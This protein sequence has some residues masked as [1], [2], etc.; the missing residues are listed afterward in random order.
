MVESKF[1]DDGR[2]RLILIGGC[3][4]TQKT[5][6]SYK[7]A[8]DLGVD[9]VLSLDVVK[10]CIKAFEPVATNPYLF[11]TT[12][13]A[14]EVENLNVM[15]GYRKHAGLI[16]AYLLRLLHGFRDDKVVIVEGAQLSPDFVKKLN[17]DE[18][19]YVYFNVFAPKREDLL[20]SYAKKQ[21][22]RAY[23]WQEHMDEIWEINEK[24]RLE[25]MFMGKVNSRVN[26]VRMGDGAEHLMLEVIKKELA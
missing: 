2:T 14:H 12:Q 21:E 17:P 13:E 24:L 7:L 8:L 20:E 22:I 10:E 25:T 11:T 15:A 5:T 18:Y 1:L 9:K 16:Q 19:A 4:G 6:L 23:L 3:A 26:N